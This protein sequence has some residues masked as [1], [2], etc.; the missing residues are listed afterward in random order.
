MTSKDVKCRAAVLAR[1]SRIE[2]QARGVRKM[3]EEERDCVAVL[4]QLAAI[5]GAIRATARMIVT[6]H[7]ESCL[8]EPFVSEQD[9]A[10]IM[11][12]LSDIFGRFS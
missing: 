7:L 2:G 3:V 6:K 4:R 9:R 12:E 8:G 5:D 11:Q 10:R 1:L